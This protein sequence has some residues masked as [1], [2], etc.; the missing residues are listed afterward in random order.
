MSTQMVPQLDL[1]P[2]LEEVR[3]ALDE[4]WRRVIAS[5]HFILGPEVDSLEQEVASH[6][7]VK[8]AIGVNSGTDA[9]TIALRALG[10]GP[11]AE[12]IT[13]PFTFFATAE[14]VL[15][16][17]ATPVFVDVDPTDYCIRAESI[18][19]RISHRTKAI[20]PVH[21]FGHAVDMDAIL[22][23]ARQHGLSVLE[24][25]AQAFGGRYRGR[26]LGTI[27][28]AGAFSFFPTK[29]L[30]C[31]GDGG[32][33][34]TNDS[35]LASE[36]RMLR[37]HGSRRKYHNESIGYN[38]RLDALQAA[39]LRAKLPHVAEWNACRRAAAQR[40]SRLLE[41]VRA[42]ALPTPRHGI[43]HVYHQYTVRVLGGQREFV[44][45]SLDAAGIGTAVYYPRPIHRL[46]VFRNEPPC[47]VAESLCDEVLSLPLW[48]RI[49]LAQQEAVTAVLRGVLERA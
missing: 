24:D 43:E 9:L 20:V 42:L 15:S 27:G 10:V 28:D 49:S 17:G 25:A 23:L 35:A 8:E 29:N 33:I 14:A 47:P 13:S 2:E 46:P 34:A 41:G 39:V 3:P 18:E 6:L 36:C 16:V 26:F 38:S 22:E 32:L 21:L 48:P 31:M 12:V 4:A 44:M 11:G 37:A 19:A 45:K 5:G 30:G 7:G 40:Y 1:L